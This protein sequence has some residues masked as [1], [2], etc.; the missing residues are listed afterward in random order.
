MTFVCRYTL[1]SDMLVSPLTFLF[2]WFSLGMTGI[3][4]GDV[5]LGSLLVCVTVDPY[6]SHNKGN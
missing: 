1:N 2:G 5:V 6:T 4:N 3:T